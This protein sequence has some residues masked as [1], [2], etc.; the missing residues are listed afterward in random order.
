MVGGESQAPAIDPR[1][2][3]AAILDDADLLALVERWSTHLAEMNSGVHSVDGNI[4]DE[5]TE[6]DATMR[7]Q[8]VTTSAHT[9]GGVLVKLRVA[10]DDLEMPADM[11]PLPEALAVS[12]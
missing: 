4:S 3:D 6:R 7:R 5:A 11:E 12:T 1:H 10:R 2:P 8:I 9:L